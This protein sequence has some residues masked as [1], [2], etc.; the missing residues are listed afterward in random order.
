MKISTMTM[1]I[2][3][4][5]LFL[6]G[7]VAGSGIGVVY[8]SQAKQDSDLVEKVAA[9]ESQQQA[10][11]NKYQAL[12]REYNRLREAPP[13]PKPAP[14]SSAAA[15]AAPAAA[16]AAPAAPAAAAPAPAATAKPAEPAAPA[17][18]LLADFS[19][20]RVEVRPGMEIRFRDDST[21]GKIT[22]WLWDFGDGTTSKEQNPIHKFEQNG[23][24][25]VTLKVTSS[26]GTDTVKKVKFIRVAEDCNC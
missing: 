16:T 4:V 15:P 14:T 1:I 6:A 25:T 22:E 18:A 3:F 19:S 9:L 2:L 13:T 5:V 24:Y 11:D 23:E 10:A 17:G 26:G 7:M 12:V 20:D 21:G 8:G